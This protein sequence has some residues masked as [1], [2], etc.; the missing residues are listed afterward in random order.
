MDG[1]WRYIYVAEDG[2]W[3]D[4]NGLVVLDTAQWS[5]LDREEFDYWPEEVRANYL[6]AFA[7]F[8]VSPVE[9]ANRQWP[10][11]VTQ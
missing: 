2:S 7:K 11:E 9:Y 1:F 4:A 6:V 5:D 3:G 8:R 10:E